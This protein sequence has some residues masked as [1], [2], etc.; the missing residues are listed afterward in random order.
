MKLRK[1]L[2]AAAT[3]A[4][5]S[6]SGI[7]AAPAFADQ[8]TTGTESTETPATGTVKVEDKATEDTKQAEDTKTAE[9]AELAEPNKDSDKNEDA[10][11]RE[12]SKVVMNLF[13]DKNEKTNEYQ[14]SADKVKAWIGVF[15]AILGAITT[16]ITFLDKNFGIKFK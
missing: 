16:L 8:S 2:L 12:R 10:D 13:F 6:F 15:T 7:V 5:V 9:G 11:K 14:L 4:T 3:A 1:G